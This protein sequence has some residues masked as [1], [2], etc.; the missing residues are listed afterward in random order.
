[1]LLQDDYL[2]DMQEHYAGR[3]RMHPAS[4]IMF[5]DLIDTARALGAAEG[6]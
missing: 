1:L 2:L 6:E 5:G 3:S 4:S